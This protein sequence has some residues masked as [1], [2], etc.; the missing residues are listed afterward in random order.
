MPQPDISI[1]GPLEVT[2]GQSNTWSMVASNVTTGG[3]VSWLDDGTSADDDTPFFTFTYPDANANETIEVSYDAQGVYYN[4]S[5][6]V[7]VYGA[8][9][10]SISAKYL[11]IDAGITD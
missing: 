9:S 3:S 10:V 5:I 1:A 8:P 6:T 4:S 7:H 2:V 11:T